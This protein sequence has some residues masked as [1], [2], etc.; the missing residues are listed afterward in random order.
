MNKKEIKKN[1]EFLMSLEKQA[2]AKGLLAEAATKRIYELA[3]TLSLEDMVAIDE[4]IQSH[5]PKAKN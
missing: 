1:A 2:N 3:L 4:Y 5:Y